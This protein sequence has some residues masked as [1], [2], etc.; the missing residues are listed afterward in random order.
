MNHTQKENMPSWVHQADSY[1]RRRWHKDKPFSAR[2]GEYIGSAIVNLILLWVVNRIP[3]WHLDFI[4]DN[5]G[6]VLWILN[7]NIL[8]QI[9]GNLLM[10]LLDLPFIRYFSRIIMEAAGFITLIVLYYIFPFDFRNYQGFFWLNWFLPI[11]FI[12]G[13]IVSAMK[14]IGNLWKLLFWR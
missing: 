9:A 13:M 10:F 11:A 3:G 14:V 8:V 7:V 4:R 5:F 1:G 2:R 12:I 6:A